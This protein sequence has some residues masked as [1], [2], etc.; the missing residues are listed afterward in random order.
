MKS[1]QSTRVLTV[2]SGKGGVGKTVTSVNLA[3]SLALAGKSVLLFDADLSLA[4]VDLLLGIKPKKTIRDL[5]NGSAGI[6]EVIVNGP[7]GLS[8]LPATSGFEGLTQITP[9][10]RY[11]IISAVEELGES[12]DFLLIDTAAGIGSSVTFFATAAHE[13]I[14]VVTPDLTSITDAYALIKVLSEEHRERSFKIIVN[15][16]DSQPHG[17][18]VFHRLLTHTER[19]LDCSMSLLGVVPRDRLVGSSIAEQQPL[20]ISFPSSPAALALSKVSQ[21]IMESPAEYRA[22]GGLQFFFSQLLG[23]RVGA[24]THKPEFNRELSR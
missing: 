23:E 13:N 2:S 24:Y 6:E 12:Y 11:K 17:V 10:E 7:F 21:E 14:V 5:L 16:A 19:F 8:V 18:R 9:A 22:K 3:T 4:N 20:V 1:L 15:M